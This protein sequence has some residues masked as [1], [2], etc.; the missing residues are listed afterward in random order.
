MRT[1][2]ENPQTRFV[3]QSVRYDG[4]TIFHSLEGV[5]MEQRIEL[6]VIEDFQM[7]YCLGLSLT[8]LLPICIFPRFDFLLLAANQ[9]VNHLDKLPLFGWTPKVIIR[10]RVGSRTPLDAGPQHTQDHTL[11][12]KVMCK[13]VHVERVS[14]V[15]EV[16][17]A[18]QEAVAREVSSLIVEAPCLP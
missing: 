7:G 18:Y 15:N 9:L 17:T 8:G 10:T 4:A 6:P 16:L 11:A 3:G 14:T 1:L 5:P 13:T 2:A 12:F